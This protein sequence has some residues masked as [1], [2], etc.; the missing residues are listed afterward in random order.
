MPASDLPNI[1]LHYRD[2]NIP[3]LMN[4]STPE[5][6]ALI[7]KKKASLDLWA[8]KLEKFPLAVY[9]IRPLPII[10]NSIRINNKVYL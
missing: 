10:R 5:K 8:T 3:I 7:Q 2:K 9:A 6:Y 1:A 4:G